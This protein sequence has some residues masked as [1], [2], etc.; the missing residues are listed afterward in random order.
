MK[1]RPS[2]SSSP[3][4]SEVAAPRKRKTCRRYNVPGDAHALTFSCFQRRPFLSRDRSRVWLVDALATARERHAFDLW[5]YVIM[6]EHVHLLIFPR[7]DV[8][9]IADILLDIKRPVARQAL[10]Y[11]REHAP[12]FLDR[13]KDEQPN[14]SVRHRFW[15]RGGGYDRNL[16]RTQIVHDTLAYIH[17]NPVRRGLVESPVAWRWSSAGFYQG[18][19]DVP[20]DQVTG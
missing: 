5:A 4:S 11:V 14:G 13:M 15:Q 2:S 18:E 3:A 8:Y 10:R 16:A 12:G 17:A 9:S 19:Q 1:Q 6:P 7:E 20:L